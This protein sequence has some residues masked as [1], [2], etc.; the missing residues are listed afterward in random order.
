MSRAFNFS[1]G[2]ATLPEPVMLEV[3]RDLLDYQGSGT[4]VVE[5]S[6]R[7]PA[8][9]DIAQ[10]AEASLR[11]LLNVSEDYLVL[12]LQGGATLQ[13]A[14][15]PLNLSVQGETV[16]YLDTG[17]WSQKAISEASYLRNVHV[18][19]S[20]TDSVPDAST[21]DRTSNSQYLHITSNETISG[22]QIPDYP[23]DDGVT[24]VADMTSDILTRHLD[25]DKFGLVYAGTQKNMG[26]SG[27]SIVIVRKDLCREPRQ[28]EP[29]YLN[30]RIHA[31]NDSMYNTPNTFAWYVSG[32]VFDWL[33]YEG[34]VAEMQRR[35][36]EKSRKIYRVI[37][38]SSL[39]F[40]TVEPAFRSKV[41]VTF[42]IRDE[43][44]TDKFLTK[45]AEA[46]IVNIKGH[47]KVGGFRVSLYN[48]VTIEA[49]DALVDFM[50]TFER[51][52]A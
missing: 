18:V 10:R 8:F 11:R 49:V 32:L 44:L 13:F 52:I 29:L 17:L 35:C 26:P 20:S 9:M 16:E 14:M 23:L 12:F 51:E 43:S 45:A 28:G 25:I 38:D 19:A 50:E 30:Y 37:N 46:N 5:I 33:L 42:S 22:V 2:P 3:Q 7:S 4:S 27:V 24:L 39:Y 48:G 34:G 41:N 40:S 1:A 36:E 6:H 15:V 47:R 31:E 21:W